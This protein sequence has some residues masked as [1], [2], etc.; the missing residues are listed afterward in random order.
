MSYFGYRPALE[1]TL[2]NNYYFEEKVHVYKILRKLQ[3]FVKL[4]QKFMSNK[5]INSGSVSN[6]FIFVKLMN[7][8]HLTFK[9]LELR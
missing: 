5:I 9:L 8:H 2:I 4:S 6:F 1:I 3:S 7:I